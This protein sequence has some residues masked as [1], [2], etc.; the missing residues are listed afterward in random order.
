MTIADNGAPGSAP[1]LTVLFDGGCP[2]CSREI[3]HYQRIASHSPITW[4]DVSKPGI[5]LSAYGVTAEQA[6]R[7]FHVIDAEGHAHIGAAGFIRLWAAL[8]GYRWLAR[9]CRILKLTPLLDR[10]YVRFADWR[11]VRRCR[12]GVCG[13]PGHD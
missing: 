11:F 7:W 4:L 9:A 12:D 13:Q 6:M 1:T 8:P 3:A 5:P 2:L 10:I